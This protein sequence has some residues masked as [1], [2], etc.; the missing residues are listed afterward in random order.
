LAAAAQAQTLSNIYGLGPPYG[1]E[2]SDSP[3]YCSTAALTLGN[4]GNFYGTAVRNDKNAPLCQAVGGNVCGTIFMI[5]PSGALTTLYRFSGQADGAGPVPTLTL[6]SDGNFYGTTY[7]GGTITAATTACQYGCGTVFQMTPSGALTT[8]YSFSGPDGLNPSGLTLG[9]DGNFYGTTGRG[10]SSLG[11]SACSLGCGTVF[12]L[13]PSATLTTLYNFSGPDGQY[14]YFAALT[15]GGD[16]NF[17]GTTEGGGSGC[18]SC[19]TVFQITP[20]GTITTFHNFSGPDGADPV[21]ALTLGGDGNLYGTTQAGGPSWTGPNTGLG[22]LFNITP[23]AAFTTLYNFSGLDG[24][25]PT[26]PLT[27]GS[28]GNFYGTMAYGGTNGLGMVF[29]FTPTGGPGSLTPLYNFSGPDGAV[30]I[31]ALTLGSDGAFYGITSSGGASSVGIVFRLNCGPN[32]NACTATGLTSSLNPSTFGTTMTFTATVIPLGRSG[33]PTGSVSF[34]DGVSPLGSAPIVGGVASLTPEM[35]SG[36]QHTITASYSGDASFQSSAGTVT[37]TVNK[38][39]TNTALVSNVNPSSYNQPLTFTAT[40]APT[41]GSGTPTGTVLFRDGSLALGKAT[42]AGGV[43]SFKAPVL[44]V[45]THSITATYSGDQSCLR[46]AGSLSQVVSQATTTTALKSSAIAILSNL[47]VTF[48]ATV[49]GEYGGNPT[50]TVTFAAN[51]AQI[52]SP[53]QVASKKASLTTSFANPG[54][55]SIAASYSGDANF[56]AGDAPSL[57]ET[58]DQTVQTT[59]SVKSSGSPSALGN[60]VTF[61]ATVRPALGSIPNGETVTFYDGAAAIGTGATASGVAT[62]SISFLVAG[63]HPIA[64]AYTGDTTYLLSTSAVVNQFVSKNATT[65]V[66]S[67]SLNPATYGQSVTFTATATSSGQTPTGMVVFRNGSAVLGTGALSAGVATLASTKLPAGTDSITATYGGDASSL[68]STSAPLNQS[69]TQAAT[70]T[71]VASSK[72]PS[73]QG[74]SVTF[75]A[76]VTSPYATVTG[77]VIFTLGSTTLGT[78]TLAG[79]NARLAVTTL[80]P[81]PDT[82]TATYGGTANFSGSSGS[83]VQTVN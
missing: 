34:A 17:Y 32:G 4:D 64:A 9:S 47:Q 39:A 75:T 73:T 77:T 23:S 76:T 65:T 52:G 28:D 49:T 45:G 44:A 30:P 63:S 11:S 79:G 41:S 16:G 7:A 12:Q 58:V 66:L 21:A 3:F 42:L 20:S 55:Y 50:G 18:P 22:T 6:G 33:N 82:V 56:T 68:S 69:V 61:T 37:Q 24:E 14:P 81:G 19:G 62:F 53:V 51:G 26:A 72:N 2:C 1:G 71:T 38:I 70:T 35:L 40:E 43:A 8:L 54:T 27:L 5:A 59:T 29:E 13:T 46:G 25:N 60:P 78:V 74:K 36:G 80:P 31:A 48:T 83:I 15:P 10:G 57:N 67:S